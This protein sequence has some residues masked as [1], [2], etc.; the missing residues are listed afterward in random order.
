LESQ[1]RLQLKISMMKIFASV[2]VL[3]TP[4]DQD[5]LFNDQ[6]LVKCPVISTS[7]CSV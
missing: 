3:L 2:E 6:N 7:Y 5:I 4:S 1:L